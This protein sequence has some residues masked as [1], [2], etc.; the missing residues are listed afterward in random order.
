MKTN[1]EWMEE[2]FERQGSRDREKTVNNV[3]KAILLEAGIRRAGQ[4]IRVN[5]GRHAGFV[6]EIETILWSE[7]EV[8]CKGKERWFSLY[9]DREYF[10]VLNP[11][12]ATPPKAAEFEL[13][14]EA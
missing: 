5:Q 9:H 11:S 6:G 12:K 13:P 14:A 1:A 4:R 10:A 3:C 2:F 7:A 8:K